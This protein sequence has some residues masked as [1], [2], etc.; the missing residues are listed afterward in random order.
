MTVSPTAITA[1]RDELPGALIVGFRPLRVLLRPLPSPLADP[2]RCRVVV[3]VVLVVRR[4]AAGR[5]APATCSRSGWV[6]MLLLT[7]LLQQCDH[8]ARGRSLDRAA[9]SSSSTRAIVVSPPLRRR[10]PPPPRRAARLAREAL[11][12]RLDGMPKSTSS[13]SS[14]SSDSV[15]SDSDISSTAASPS[16]SAS[17]SSSMFKSASSSRS[18]R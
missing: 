9:A 7:T 2:R 5:T 16:F 1:A 4:R 13:S 11:P 17:S 6:S 18:S 10:P 8:P 14:S 12:R 15:S 3:L